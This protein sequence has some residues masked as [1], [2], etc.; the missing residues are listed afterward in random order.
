MNAQTFRRNH[1]KQLFLGFV[2]TIFADLFTLRPLKWL[3]LSATLDDK[4]ENFVCDSDV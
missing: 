1:Q 3:N 4:Y 2:A